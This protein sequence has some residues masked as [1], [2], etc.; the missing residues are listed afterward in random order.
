MKKTVKKLMVTLALAL[1]VT[2]F[3]GSGVQAKQKSQKLKVDNI[4]ADY[5][6][7]VKGRC[8]LKKYRLVIKQGSKVLHNKTHYRKSFSVKIGTRNQGDKITHQLPNRL[9]RHCGGRK[10][11]TNQ[12]KQL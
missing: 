12:K 9:N 6:K 8:N 10:M 11:A 1:M 7:Y 3:C 5:N 2:A 4:Y